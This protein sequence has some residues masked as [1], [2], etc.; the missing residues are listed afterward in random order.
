MSKYKLPN[1]RGD[2]LIGTLA[3]FVF[4]FT[5]FEENIFTAEFGI[6]SAETACWDIVRKFLS[7]QIFNEDFTCRSTFLYAENKII[8]NDAHFKARD[9]CFGHAF[10]DI[11]FN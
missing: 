7:S 2:H 3:A 9:F 11:Y 1:L 8:P 5:V 4:I 6:I 10:P